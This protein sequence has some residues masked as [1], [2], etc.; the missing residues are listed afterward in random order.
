MRTADRLLSKPARLFARS[1]GQTPP[2]GGVIKRT[3]D[4]T[5][6]IIALILLAPLFLMIGAL[7]K[8]SDGGS[9]LYGH[10]RI[11][12]NG[13]TF[14]CLK[15]RTMVENG[16]EVLQRHLRADPQALEEWTAT[17][18]LQNDPRVTR[19]GQV[20]RKL[21]LD[22]LPQILNI[23][24]GEMSVVGPRPV[25]SEELDYYGPAAEFY[26]ASRPGLTGLWQVSGRSDLDWEQAVRLD[27]Y[28]VE[29]WSVAQDLLIL[30]RTL[31]AVLAKE[32]AY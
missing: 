30:W 15:F 24:R 8:A 12:R 10:K 23:V 13:E 26:L 7:V 31:S 28:Y 2:I 22:E 20:L 29:N 5:A 32:G 11:G 18:K 19:V 9:I 14:R 27:L 25:V 21:S 3:F 6:A 17:R 1:E 16:D 4:L